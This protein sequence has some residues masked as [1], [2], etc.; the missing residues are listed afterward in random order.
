VLATLGTLLT[1]FLGLLGAL[2]PHRAAHLVGIKPLGGF[3]TSEIR[4]TYGGLFLAMGGSCL[5]LQHPTAYFVVASAWIGAAIARLPSL[6]IDKGSFPKAIGGVVVELGIGL[7]LLT[8]A[9]LNIQ[10]LGTVFR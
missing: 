3:G 2:A 4:A 7:L 1:V 9:Q 5:Y 8:G 10:T 6:I